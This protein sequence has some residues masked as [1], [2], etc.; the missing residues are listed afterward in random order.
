MKKHRDTCHRT[1]HGVKKQRE[2]IK[3]LK[4]D[5]S[6]K[7]VRYSNGCRVLIDINDGMARVPIC[8]NPPPI[9]TIRS[10]IDKDI[11]KADEN[12]WHFEGEFIW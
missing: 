12:S 4:K 8:K 10:Q 6:V 11:N 3:E 5:Y 2:V 9:K 1:R 7:V